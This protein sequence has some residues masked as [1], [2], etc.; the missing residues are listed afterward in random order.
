MLSKCA[1]PDCSISSLEEAR[2]FRFSVHREPNQPPVNRHSVQHFWLC[3]TCSALYTLEY[4]KQHGIKIRPRLS[5]GTRTND[6][7]SQ[8]L[9]LAVASSAR[10]SR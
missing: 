7:D 9:T 2:F 5:P 3:K 6:M 10:K 4:H 1:N 8:P